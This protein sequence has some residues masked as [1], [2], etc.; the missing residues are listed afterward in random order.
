MKQKTSNLYKG[1]PQRTKT[2]KQQKTKNKQQKTNNKKQKKEKIYQ[3]QRAS[4]FPLS[5]QREGRVRAFAKRSIAT[6]V[7][8]SP[9]AGEDAA[10]RQVR[11]LAKSINRKAPIAKRAVVSSHLSG[12]G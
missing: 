11:G 12:G 1:S 4:L 5:C 2:D 9:L 8:S 10:K 7:V 6:R 3:S